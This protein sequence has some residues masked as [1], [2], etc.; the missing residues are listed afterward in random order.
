[1]AIK[2]VE[3]R[4]WWNTHAVG[5]GLQSNHLCS[6]IA[7][8]CGH[9]CPRSDTYRSDRSSL[10][11]YLFGILTMQ[12]IRGH[13][14]TMTVTM[15]HKVLYRK[16]AEDQALV[17]YLQQG[18]FRMNTLQTERWT[19]HLALEKKTKCR[20]GKDRSLAHISGF[21]LTRAL[22]AGTTKWLRK[23]QSHE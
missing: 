12:N 8:W 20:N 16:T 9:N 18:W 7:Q 1:M 15:Q 10:Q 22:I 11:I 4:K 17:L 3:L 21:L 13:N 6:C 19:W 23:K 2:F 5:S 14:D